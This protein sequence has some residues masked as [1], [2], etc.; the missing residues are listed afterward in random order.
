[1]SDQLGI[2]GDDYILSPQQIKEYHE[3]GYIILENVIT[4][5]EL[6]TI[7]SLYQEFIEGKV[8]GMGK[9]FCDMIAHSKSF[10]WSTQ[11]CRESIDRSW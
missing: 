7:E 9:D 10:N 11:Y 3:K 5:S 1:M 2:S 4:E 8:P 6:A